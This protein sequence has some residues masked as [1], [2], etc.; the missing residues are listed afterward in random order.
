MLP[1]NMPRK[2]SLTLQ[3]FITNLATNRS[4]FLY[5]STVFINLITKMFPND[6]V[7]HGLFI[8]ETLVT[9]LTIEIFLARMDF[10]M[11]T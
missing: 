7:C 6:V 10:H 1:F 5:C 3:H 2:C 4:L 8:H 11:S 9:V